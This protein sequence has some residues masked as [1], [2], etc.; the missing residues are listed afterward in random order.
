MV[1]IFVTEEAFEAISGSRRARDIR[2]V[3]GEF[4]K[5]PLGDHLSEGAAQLSKDRCN[6]L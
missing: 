3:T 5:N 2:A 4:G 1:R 6:S